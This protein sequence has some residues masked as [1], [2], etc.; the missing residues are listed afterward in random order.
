MNLTEDMHAH[1]T[2]SDGLDSIDRNVEMAIRR[3][4][5]KFCQVDHV[6]AGSDWLPEYVSAVESARHRHGHLIEILCGV[7]A[8]L[9]NCRGDLD[10][11]A[12][13]DGVDLLLAA[14]HQ[15]PIGSAC[16][17]PREVIE[18]IANGTCSVQDLLGG[19]IDAYEGVIATWTHRVILAHPFSILPKVGLSESQL[20]TDRV[21]KL[22]TRAATAGAAVEVSERWKCPSA[23]TLVHFVEEGVTC[24]ASTDAHRARD[25]GSYDYVRQTLESMRTKR[26]SA[27]G[28]IEA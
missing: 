12:L 15:F 3:G 1:S 18:I 13:P 4:L 11:P 2:F 21:R 23:R 22:A 17:T 28:S 16:F 24:Y 26:R 9:L 14:D 20:M 10:L 25:I 8:K 7:E 5:K 27:A 6:R 19:L